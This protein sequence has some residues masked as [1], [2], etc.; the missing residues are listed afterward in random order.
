MN[1]DGSDLRRITFSSQDADPAWSPDGSRIAVEHF[2]A[3]TGIGGL[4]TLSASGGDYILVI[5]HDALGEKMEPQWSPDR[6]KLVF[7][8]VSDTNGSAI[9]TVNLDGTGQR[10]I[11]PF[12]FGFAHPDW[13]PDGRLIVF[14]NYTDGAPQG[15]STNVFT[16]HPDGTHL[17]QVSHLQGGALNATNP[18]WS[19]DGTRIVFVEVPGSGHFGYADVYTMQAD[20]TDVRQVTNSLFWDFRPS[21]GSER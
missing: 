7:Q 15:V 21:W 10:Q 5:A 1:A 20:G 14:E 3:S 9:F 16:V 11:T 13:S 19:P 2:D 4:Y 17:T 6:T 18:A 12:G 8:I